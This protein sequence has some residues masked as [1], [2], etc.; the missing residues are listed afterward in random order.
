MMDWTAARK[1]RTRKDLDALKAAWS[2]YVVER[3]KRSDRLRAK[4]VPYIWKWGSSQDPGFS[5][6]KP[7]FMLESTMPGYSLEYLPREPKTVDWLSEVAALD[8]TEP[9]RNGWIDVP[10]QHPT[11]PCSSR[12]TRRLRSSSRLV[13]RAP[14]LVIE[15]FQVRRCNP[16]N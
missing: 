9:W 10:E 4:V 1:T 15:S 5:E 6:V 12:A 13:L 14:V 16:V 2:R 7:E 8:A 11:T 3:N